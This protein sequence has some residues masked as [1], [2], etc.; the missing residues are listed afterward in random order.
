MRMLKGITA[1]VALTLC[2]AA[3]EASP[4]TGAM[5]ISGNFKPVNGVTGTTTTLGLATGLDFIALIGSTSTPGVAGQFVVNS[6]SGMLT[7]YLG[8]TGQIK[9]FSFSGTGSTSFPTLSVPLISFQSISG[10]TFTLTS[11]TTVFQMPGF[12]L[13][14]LTGTGI[15][16]MANYEDTAATFDFTANGAGSTFSFSASNGA[17]VPEPASLALLGG[18]LLAA[19]ATLSRRRRTVR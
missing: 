19:A 14:A 16:K 9:D 2:T 8:G 13:L 11:I 10:L 12:N 7:S 3:A 4:I 6:A 1:V 18:G 17:Q 15:L 5:S